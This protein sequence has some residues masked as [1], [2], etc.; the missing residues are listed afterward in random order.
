MRF[1]IKDTTVCISGTLARSSRTVAQRAI[2]GAGGRVT[3][4]VGPKTDLLVLNGLGGS[5]VDR[6]RSLGVPIITEDGLDALLAG[7]AIEVDAHTVTSGDADASEAIAPARADLTDLR[8]LDVGDTRTTRTFWRTLRT[9]P[10]TRTLE[11]LVIELLD[12]SAVAGALGEHHCENLRELGIKNS[13]HMSGH[14]FD[15]LLRADLCQGVR[16][17]SCRGGVPA[18]ALAA[19]ADPLATP[20]LEHVTVSGYGPHLVLPLLTAAVAPRL[21]T[22]SIDYAFNM[23]YRDDGRPLHERILPLLEAWLPEDPAGPT[24][25]D[26]SGAIFTVPERESAAGA[27]QDAL[28]TLAPR[29]PLP[30]GTTT[31]RLG[32]WWSPELADAMS[33]RHITATP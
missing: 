2:V 20:R 17:I 11:R 24:T 30:P 12:D 22:L 32:P 33:T 3:N 10:S 31:L 8:A 27:V 16:A 19:L 15:A 21:E 14:A 4:T 23:A 13:R 18:P 7:Y 5:K 29:W 9:L 26:L 6:A 28:A 25:L 1:T